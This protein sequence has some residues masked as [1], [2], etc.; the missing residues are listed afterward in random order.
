[1]GFFQTLSRHKALTSVLVLLGLVII[2]LVQNRDY[3]Q[4]RV[5]FWQFSAHKVLF[6]A[7]VMS[8]GYLLGKL[9]EFSLRK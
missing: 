5:F 1:M 4:F 6:I 8:F 2:I 7:G 9:I 3:V